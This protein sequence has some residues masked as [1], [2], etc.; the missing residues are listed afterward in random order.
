MNEYN[1][2][3]VLND[4]VELKDDLV[5]KLINI[6]KSTDDFYTGNQVAFTLVENFKDDDRIEAC[7][8][9]LITDSRWKNHNGT[10]LYLL[11]EYTNNK[12]YLYFLIDI[13]LNNEKEDNGEIFMGAYSMIINLH[14]PLDVGEIKRALQR[15]RIEEKKENISAEQKKMVNSLLNY[16][17]GQQK[18]AE[19]YSQ[20]DSDNQ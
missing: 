3:T 20:F 12:K 16:L 15:V 8:I 19:F 2:E 18:I 13:I 9:N 6:L 1:I 17:K 5:A 4:A 7:L 11:G 10:L 14:P